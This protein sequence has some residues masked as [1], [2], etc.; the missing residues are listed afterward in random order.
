MARASRTR[1]GVTGIAA[2]C[3]VL[4]CESPVAPQPNT[5]LGLRV[6]ATVAPTRLS[7]RDSTASF[8]IRVYVANPTGDTLRVKSGGPPYTFTP[9]PAQ[10]RGLKQSF[11]IASATEPLNAGPNTDYWG[12]S[13]YV[14]PP[15]QVEYTEAVVSV[16]AW[17]VGGWALETGPLRVRGWFNGHEGSS[18]PFQLVP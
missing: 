8:R 7:T 14:F 10:S 13:V 11:R 1:L 9:D 12:D 15:H 16:R 3:A 6:W 4:S 5:S 17:R 18:A 2:A